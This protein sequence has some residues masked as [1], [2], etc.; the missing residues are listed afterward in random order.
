MLRTLFVLIV[1]VI[2]IGIV[3]VM[4][5]VVNLRDTGNGVAVETR[6]VEIG[7]AP[8]NVQVPTVTTENR[9]VDLPAVRIEG[10]SQ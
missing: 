4:T 10:N 7:T 8:V 2:A 6:D 1:L 3:L 9:Q 5:G